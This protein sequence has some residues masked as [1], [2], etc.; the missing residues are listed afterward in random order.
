MKLAKIASLWIDGSLSWLEHASLDSF[1]RLGHE[2]TL[3]TY[4]TVTNV[5]DG[6]EVR[7]AREVWSED[8]VIVHGKAGSPAIHADIF[9]AI[10]VANTDFVWVDADVIAL[11]PF[12]ASMK[13][14]LGYEA[15][16]KLGNAV[17][18]APRSA[19]TVKAL[20]KDLT[21][22]YAVPSWFTPKGQKEFQ[23]RRENKVRVDWGDLPWGST[24]PQALTYFANSTGEIKYA[25]PEH[26]FFPVSFKER[27]MLVDGKQFEALQNRLDNEQVLSVHLYSRWMRKFTGG[28]LPRPNSWIGQYLL[29]HDLAAESDMPKP[30]EKRKKGKGKNPKLPLVD[31]GA[32]FQDLAVRKENFKG[33]LPVTRNGS[34]VAVTMAKDEGPYILE[35]VAYHRLLGFSDILVYT[36]DSTDG[37][38]E[39][40][41]ALASIGLVTR[42][43]N[44][45]IGTK[46]P[47]SRA[48]MRAQKHPLVVSADWVM[49]FDFDEFVTIRRGENRV[50]DLVDMVRE[51]GADAIAITWRFFGS[52]GRA[53][54]EDYPVTARF[55][56]SCSPNFAK[57]YG[58]KTLFKMDQSLK[59]AIHRPHFGRDARKQGNLEMN[60]VNGGGE[61]IDGRLMTWR[62]N[63]QAA[64]YAF[65]QVNHYGVKSGEEFL[66]R[67]LRGDVLNNHGKYDDEYFQ[68]FDRNEVADDSAED[69]QTPLRELI[70]Q[71]MSYPRILE[72][73]HVVEQRYGAKIAKL[74]RSEGY[75]QQMQS[76]GFFKTTDI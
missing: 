59:L 69:M 44:P 7:D 22:P 73:A 46:P 72:A 39:M 32:F 24:G 41:D 57:G 4:G 13:W 76:L 31:S 56:R 14:F 40:L 35:W 67:R 12:P 25:Q 26:V 2:M 11:R 43:D 29:K 10:M 9:R 63:R 8:A 51:C 53:R 75:Q 42:V 55:I 62:Q 33:T 18:G 47:Q 27:K 3:F 30:E 49:V 28:H 5:P 60:W 64:N 21:D 23:R 16:G 38:D 71:L 45:P 20:V 15:P 58:V 19:K 48:L 61:P 37:T 66:M 6:V 70:S 34:L 50:D 17:M 74:R 65:C 36:N 52:G 1:V 68:T 54:Y